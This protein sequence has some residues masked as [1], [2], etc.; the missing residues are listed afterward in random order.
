[1]SEIWRTVADFPDY[2]VSNYGRVLR[3]TPGKRTRPDT[4]LRQQSHKG[5]LHVNLSWRG[6]QSLCSVATLVCT[7][8]HGPRP[9]PAHEVLH[10]D[11]DS[12][13]NRDSNLRWGTRKE[14]HADRRR[15]GKELYGTDRHNGI[16]TQDYVTAIRAEPKSYGMCAR[17]AQQYGV[18]R[19]Y[20]KDIRSGQKRR[21]G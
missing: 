4:L 14:N 17:L 6:K 7:A 19:R 21:H 3:A 18:S 11:D 1:M 2:E 12:S 15:N 16:L 5:Y 20:I 13:N 9:S 8:F 10:W